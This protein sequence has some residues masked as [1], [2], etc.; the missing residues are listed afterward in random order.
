VLAMGSPNSAFSNV[1]NA[2]TQTSTGGSGPLAAPTNLLVVPSTSVANALNL[3]WTDNATAESGYKIERSTDGVNFSPLAG[4]GANMTFYRNTNLTPGKKY[5]YRVYAV[6]STGGKSGFSNVASAV[7]PAAAAPVT[8][9][10]SMVAIRQEDRL[11]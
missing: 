6:N 2:T 9:S 11:W 4:G 10:F 8:V 5:Y 3:S 1:A 7:V